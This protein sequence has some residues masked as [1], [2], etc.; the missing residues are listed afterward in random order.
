[1]AAKHDR[2]ARNT[3]DFLQ[4]ADELTKA[5]CRL[6]M[7]DPDIDLGTP[8]GRM[9]ATMFAAFAE[10]ERNLISGRVMGGKVEPRRKYRRRVDARQRPFVY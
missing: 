10:W 5:G 4:T 9:M 6:V 2:L 1:M 7:L 8:A 3:V